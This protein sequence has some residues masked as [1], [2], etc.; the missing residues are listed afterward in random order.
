MLK[1][2]LFHFIG[3]MCIVKLNVLGLRDDWVAVPVYLRALRSLLLRWNGAAFGGLKARPNSF[4]I[5]TRHL[6]GKDLY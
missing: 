2:S 5:K 1:L 3:L 4:F 6:K